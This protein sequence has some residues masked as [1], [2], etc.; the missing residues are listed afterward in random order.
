MTVM[1]INDEL[2]E[3]KRTNAELQQKLDEAVAERDEVQAQKTAMSEV[4]EVINSS[5]GDLA[6]MFDAMIEKALN[7]CKAAFGCLFTYDGEA[8]HSAAQRGMS[9]ALVDYLREPIK[10]RTSGYSQTHGSLQ[11][12]IRGESVV[13]HADLKNSEAYRNGLRFIRALVDFDDGRTALWV[14]LRKNDRLLGVFVI[15]RR[16][17]RPFSDKQIALLQNF[18]AQAVIAMENA[19]LINETREA[20]EQQ[21]ATAEVL[22]VINSSPGDLAPVFDAILDKAY[23]LC[24]ADHGSLALYDGERF[25]AVAVSSGSNPFAKRLREGVRAVGNPIG[26]PLLDGARFVHI[27]DQAEVDHP[28]MQAAVKETGA[29]TVLAVPLRKDNILLGMIVAVRQEVRPFTDKQI[30]LLQNFAAQAVIAMENARLLDEIRQRQQELR[31]TFD[32]MVDGVVM[33]DE[34]LHL[35]AW[36]RNFQE[37]LQLPDD[38]LAKRHEFDTYIRHLV[39]RGEFGETDPE[40]QI[41][42]L[43]ARIGDHYSFERTRPDGTV[44]EVRHNPMPGGGIV[45]IYSDITKRKRSEAEIK[46]ARDAAEAA[47]LDLKA[48]QA[49]LIQAEK[50][51]SLGQLTAGIA[52]EIKNP[53]NFV[54]N[55]ANLSVELLDELKETAAPAINSLG[56]EERAEIGEVIRMLTG[57]LEKIAEHGR[58]ADGIVTSMLEHSRGSSGERRSVDLNHLVED[59]LNLAY[60]G[61]RAQDQSFNITLEHDFDPAIAPIELVPQDITRVCLNLISNGFYASRKREKEGSDPK[62]KPTLK[63]STRDLGDA[64][65]INIR[66]NG[67]GIPPENKDKLFQPFFTTKPTGEGTGLGLSISYDI[68]TQQHGGTI[69]VDSRVDE[70]T[71]FAIRLPRVR[72]PSAV[73]A[74]RQSESAGPSIFEKPD[75]AVSRH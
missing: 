75:M 7:L 59:A 56:D 39:E 36:N 22:G 5:P 51:A 37:L 11:Q 65:E 33:F 45:L 60:H 64:V 2:A 27:P 67:V 48:A 14:A 72:Q 16:E 70:F 31:V 20:L 28:L 29:R 12:L 61:A 8:F 41:A 18:A 46:A 42:R 13:H 9:A 62:F 55:F 26:Q 68:V 23:T 25:R 54:N 34:T 44:I 50:M 21:T 74:L 47:Y 6:P 49:N 1:T 71:E 53:L 24:G 32:N 10:P 52:H 30:A 17:V 40:T 35:A 73:Q 57:N 4:M 63:V 69:E 38:L 3:L 66:D 19:R 43:R 15:Y 58:R